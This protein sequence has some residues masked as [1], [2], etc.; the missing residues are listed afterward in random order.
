MLLIWRLIS[1]HKTTIRSI[2]SCPCG[3]SL[4]SILQRI[5]FTAPAQNKTNSR[6]II[7]SKQSPLVSRFRITRF[8]TS[9]IHAL[10]KST[11]KETNILKPIAIHSAPF[12][13]AK[14]V[15]MPISAIAPSHYSSGYKW[16][17][18]LVITN[19]IKPWWK[20]KSGAHYCLKKIMRPYR[21]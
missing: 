17:R 19:T 18:R 16:R 12:H 5:L 15:S 11:Q 7:C 6:S 13:L 1:Q 14:K 8:P 3:C 9:S 10:Q 20:R 4:I 2:I 21:S